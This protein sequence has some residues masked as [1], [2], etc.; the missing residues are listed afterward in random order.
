MSLM[1][2]N[3]MLRTQVM[4]AR[5]VAC[6][7]SALVT[8]MGMERLTVETHAGMK[9]ELEAAD[10]PNEELIELYQVD[11]DELVADHD[12]D[13]SLTV[14]VLRVEMRRVLLQTSD[15]LEQ[16]RM[17]HPACAE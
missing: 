15:A 11:K 4:L 13:A 17:S 9:I 8:L 7:Q 12:E 2:D 3:D 5:K 6:L 16:E 1:T 10:I 14:T